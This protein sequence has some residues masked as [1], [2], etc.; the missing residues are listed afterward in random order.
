MGRWARQFVLGVAVALLV[1]SRTTGRATGQEA[2]PAESTPAAAPA[3]EPKPTISEDQLPMIGDMAV[4]DAKALL[5]GPLRDWVVLITDKVLVVESIVPRPD[6]LAKRVLEIEAKQ[7]SKQGLT[8]DDLEKVKQEYDDLQYLYFTVPEQSAAPEVRIPLKNIRQIIHHE[9][10]MLKRMQL[11]VEEGNIDLALEFLNWMLDKVPTWPGLSEQT[12][13]LLMAD[14]KLRIAAGRL[15]DALVPLQE[16]H[17]RQ[18]DYVGVTEAVGNVLQTMSLAAAE[19][20]DYPQAHHHLERLRALYPNHPQVTSISSGLEQRAAEMLT[21]AEEAYKAERYD[22]AP[23]YAEQAAVI[24]PKLKNLKERHKPIV[25]RFQRL[26]V[27]VV[28]LTGEPTAFPVPIDA[29]LREERLHRTPL[30]S[31]DR[32]VNG[33]AQYRTRYFS[34]WEPYDLGRRI[35]FELRSSRQP[36]ESQPQLEAPQVVALLQAK[37]DPASD[38]FDD[39]LADSIRTIELKSPREFVVSFQRVPARIEA[40]FASIYPAAPTDPMTEGTGFRLAL[41]EADQ[42]IF[43]RARPEPPKLPQ[44]HVA[45]VVEHKYQN[46][47]RAVQALLR[48]EV[49]LIPNLPDWYIRRLQADDDA[50][51][52]F[53]ILKYSLPHT[54]V[55]LFH[56]DSPAGKSRDLRRA[57]AYAIDRDTLLKD[58]VLRDPTSAHGRLIESPFPSFSYGNSLQARKVQFDLSAAIAMAV[59]GGQQLGGTALPT[60]RMVVPP[61]Q[62]ERAAAEELVRSWKRIG[63]TVE[64]VPDDAGPQTKYDL[65]YQSGTFPE[66]VVDWWPLVTQSSRPNL[67][68]LFTKPDWLRQQMVDLDRTADWT[69]ATR[70]CQELHRRLSVEAAYLPLFEVDGY[71]VIRKNT[72]GVPQEPLHAYDQLDRWYLEAM[73][74]T[75]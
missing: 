68:D 11:L 59:A 62:V 75:P 13:A 43:R 34:E 69:L 9:D 49:S 39:R 20:E 31:L 61:S 17:S 21:R 56:P 28:R 72:R 37:I 55:I 47:D 35:R 8:G 5:T 40:L 44:Y 41:H 10:L 26:H 64:I 45:E 15:E 19:Q 29:E 50:K 70:Q 73:L 22:E 71:L 18:S 74:P 57:L 53:D 67:S 14:A 6:T 1:L 54:H 58:T 60:L 38:Q 12:N 33:T 65:L 46:Y 66:P 16:I 4:P 3:A 52:E 30:F 7:K 63:I 27:G 48:G 2:P 51:K 23:G 25:E 24:W 42:V 36:W 32:M